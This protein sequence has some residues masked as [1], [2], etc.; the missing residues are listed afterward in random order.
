MNGNQGDDV[1]DGG[2]NDDFLS[3][4]EGNDLLLGGAGWDTLVGG[5]D[6]DTASYANAPGPVDVYLFLNAVGEFDAGENH[7]SDDGLFGIEN[8]VGSAFDDAIRGDGG[9]NLLSG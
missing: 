4:D 2:D 7:L 9:A 3:G 5:S 8:V 6:T 1:L